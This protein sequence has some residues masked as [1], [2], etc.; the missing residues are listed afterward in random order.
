MSELGSDNTGHSC[1]WLSLGNSYNRDYIYIFKLTPEDNDLSNFYLN[2]ISKEVTNIRIPWLTHRANTGSVE[3][4]VPPLLC[5]NTVLG[6]C[7]T[8]AHLETVP[9]RQ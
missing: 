8:V 9:Q 7:V 1:N 5:S 2:F 3:L 4:N 6:L